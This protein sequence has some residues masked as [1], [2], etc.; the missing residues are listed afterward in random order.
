MKQNLRDLDNP[1]DE[2]FNFINVQIRVLAAILGD[3]YTKILSED[4]KQ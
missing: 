4:Y 1:T 2:E 3:L